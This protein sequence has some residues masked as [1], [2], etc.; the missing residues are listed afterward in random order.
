MRSNDIEVIDAFLGWADEGF[1]SVMVTVLSTFGAS[2]RPSGSMAVIREDGLIIGSVSGGCVEDDLVEEI[3][4]RFARLAVYPGQSPGGVDI[5][6]FGEGGD[7]QS[8][9]R[10]PCNNS[11]RV[12][13]EWSCD[14]PLLLQ[15]R[16]ALEQS[17]TVRRRVSFAT[18]AVQLSDSQSMQVFL[19]DEQGFEVSLGPH[20]RALLIGAT[21]LGRYVAA[22]LMTL[23]FAVEVCDPREEYAD[24][25]TVAGVPLSRSMP[26]D[27]VSEQRPDGRTAV[28]AMA[29]DPKLD[30]LALMEALKTRAFYVG[31]IGSCATTARRK[32]RLML[33][34]VTADEVMRLHGPIGLSIGSKTPAE[35]AVSVA[36][37][38]ISSLRQSS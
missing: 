36:A 29:H 19:E 25:W 12:A 16:R 14:I 27:W 34:G 26:D 13:L 37:D 38:L 30:D 32:E 5:R 24:A 4:A 35:I 15:A 10:L 28:L 8:R 2:P 9:Y 17:Q 33:F 1:A 11:L 31:A 23:D 22:I 7:E 6:I 18:G 20:Y 3:K 21:E